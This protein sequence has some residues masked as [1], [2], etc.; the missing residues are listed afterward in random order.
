MHTAARG[1]RRRNG[2]RRNGPRH[3][4]RW[5]AWASRP[6]EPAVAPVVVPLVPASATATAPT[7]TS[8]AG[9]RPLAQ[10]VARAGDLFHGPVDGVEAG[11]GVPGVVSAQRRLLGPANLGGV[12]APWGE[13]ARLQRPGQVGRQ[14]GYGVEALGLVLVELGNGSEQGLGVGMVD[15]LE[16]AVC[17]RRLRRSCRRT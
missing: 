6:F 12:P 1:A 15:V 16:E 17:G 5:P 10:Q 2:R 3:R 4:G 11:V 9:F 14:A 7:S 8:G 13:P